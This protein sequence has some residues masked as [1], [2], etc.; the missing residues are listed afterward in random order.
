MKIQESSRELLTA[1]KANDAAQVSAVIERHP[2]VRAALNDPLPYNYHFRSTPLLAAVNARNREMIDVL[3]RAGADINARSDWWAGS[4]GV[5]DS[6]TGLEAFLMERGARVDAHAAARMGMFGK[7]KELV[8]ANPELVHGRGG[9][10]QTPLHFASSVEIAEYL[11][12]RGAEID[13]RDIDHESTPA[14][15][16]AG[17]RQEVARYLVSRGCQTD[18]LMAAALGDL[19]LVRRHLDADPALI[20]MTVSEH[21]FPKRDL[22]AGGSIY[23]WVLGANKGAHQV[24]RE[25]GHEDVF[26]LLMERSPEELKLALACE[27]EDEPALRRMLEEQP[28][29]VTGLTDGD[30]QRLIGAAQNNNTNAVRLMLEAGWPVDTHAPDGATA[31]HWAAFHGNAAM[32]R[33]ILRFH[34][35]LQAKDFRFHGSPMGWAIHG[36]L[37]G[38]Y[39]GS[40]DYGGVVT[41]LINAGVKAP[42]PDGEASE[43]VLAVLRSRK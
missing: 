30:R 42:K 2:E 4:F 33:E 9:D 1:I 10:G 12:A 21:W 20:R 18:L 15:Y 38:W 24:A 6:A 17:K 37:H 23:T 28:E 39:C 16:M 36:S 32:A 3:L 8:A 5:L 27:F 25:Y 43:A 41:A 29:L 14:Q 34:P 35:P 31:L 7:L 11:L 13:A 22:R 40:G 19:E 26:Q